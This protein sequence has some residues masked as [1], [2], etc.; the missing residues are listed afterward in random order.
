[1]SADPLSNEQKKRLQAF[2]LAK[3]SAEK[4]AQSPLPTT[5]EE[6]IERMQ[7]RLAII[8][9]LVEL[10]QPKHDQYG[11]RKDSN[12]TPIL[13]Y[14]NRQHELMREEE[15]HVARLLNEDQKFQ[16]SCLRKRVTI[17]VVAKNIEMRYPPHP[18]RVYTG[19]TPTITFIPIKGL[20]PKP[21]R[22]KGRP[23][24]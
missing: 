18:S 20:P 14:F 22:Y 24:T 4:L 21:L 9:S 3:G 6:V 8:S 23:S 13:A 12:D 11:F 7:T 19:K 17:M 5:V 1:M 16:V 2:R 15:K 10:V